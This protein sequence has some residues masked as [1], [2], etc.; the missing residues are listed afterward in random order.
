MPKTTLFLASSGA[1]KTQAKLVV[2]AFTSP[3]VEFLPWWEAFT[4]GKTLLED[5]D[6]ISNRVDGALI[7]MTPEFEGT[8]RGSLKDIPN[9]NVLLELG[10][11]IGKFG[12]QRVAMM[13]YGDFYLPSDLGGYI[14]IHGSTGFRRSGGQAIGKRNHDEFGKWISVF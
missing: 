14:H 5:L 6:E 9:L 7:L 12:R 13:K 11:F 2:S 3:T 10:Y 4:P 1:A 8:V